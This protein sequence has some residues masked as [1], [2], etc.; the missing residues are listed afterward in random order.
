MWKVM[1]SSG[2]I[3]SKQNILYPRLCKIENFLDIRCEQY[4]NRKVQMCQKLVFCVGRYT[5]YFALRLC[6]DV[7]Y[8]IVNIQI[9]W[10]FSKL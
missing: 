5:N 6:R 2:V 8:V 10:N 9:F 3:N 4:K 7:E 1:T